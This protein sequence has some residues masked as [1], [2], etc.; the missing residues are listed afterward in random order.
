VNTRI[1]NLY[2]LIVF[3]LLV[4]VG[5]TSYWSVFD[6]DSL[7]ANR[8]NRLPLLQQQQVRRGLIVASND[9][10]LA[11][12]SVSGRGGNRFYERVYP[13]G[14]LFA[15]PVGYNF[16]DRGNTELERYYNNDLSGQGNEFA[17]LLDRLR[18]KQR[19]GDD[20]I[21]A[22]DPEGQ[23]AAL[24][25]LAGRR[26]AVVALEPATGR[27]RVLA[28]VPTYDPNSVPDDLAELNRD[29][30][31]PLL[32]R[33]TQSGYPPGSTFKVVTATA[34]LDS[35]KFEPSSV[36][37]GRSPL[38]L[39][40]APPLSNFNG[41]QFGSITLTQALTNSVNTVWAQVGAKIGAD[42]LY[43]YMDRYGFNR[44]PRID[45]P[46][47]QVRASGLYDEDGKLLRR[48]EAVDVARVAIG[49][50]RLAVTPLQ[51]AEVA[52]AIANGGKL[53][54]PHIG[55]RTRDRDGRTVDRIEPSEQSAVMKPATAA[56]LTQMMSQVVREGSGTA[57]ALAGIDVAGKT[58]TAEVGGTNQAWFI[59]FAPSE[60]PRIAVA[61]TVERTTGT[62]GEVAAPIAKQV[63]QAILEDV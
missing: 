53:M 63:M 30:G 49:Q 59:A 6:A 46:R 43:E 12:N 22:L 52:A 15:H 33:G 31:S 40:A 51:M 47:D 5:F 36:L 58:G 24:D 39:P 13:R 21:T 62:G 55:E 9:E 23:Q 48:S 20:L 61:V 56:A 54:R 7:Q 4:L 42:T 1:R 60:Q 19:E 17:T 16:V 29:E 26:G 35:G 50:E 44:K 32:D 45:L 28:S 14:A 11:R 8:H 34:A 57:A 38:Q 27:V 18:G 37:S 41:Q 3:L 25:G 10:V 2:G